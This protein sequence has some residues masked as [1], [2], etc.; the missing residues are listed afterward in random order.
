MLQDARMSAMTGRTA[1]FK[2]TIGRRLWAVS[3]LQRLKYL[4]R[5]VK[6]KK[7]IPPQHN[8]HRQ[9]RLPVSFRIF[10][11]TLSCI[12]YLVTY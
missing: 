7:A 8:H 4:E 2:T 3:S 12:E 11:T 10:S 1:A 6:L 9:N 5:S